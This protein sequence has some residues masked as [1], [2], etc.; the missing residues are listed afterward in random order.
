MG[1][2]KLSKGDKIGVILTLVTT[3]VVVILLDIAINTPTDRE[4]LEYCLSHGY[5]GVER[6]NGL[7]CTGVRDGNSVFMRF[8]QRGVR[9][10]L[11][12]Q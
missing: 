11:E 5:I 7:Y 1:N 3:L 12:E 9:M 2:A 4:K 10:W 6:G 8:T